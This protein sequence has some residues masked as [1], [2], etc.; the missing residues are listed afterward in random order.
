MLAQGLLQLLERDAFAFHLRGDHLAFA[1]DQ[2]G[3]AHHPVLEPGR[4]LGHE[5]ER[6]VGDEQHGRGDEAPDERVVVVHHAVLDGITE[7][8]QQ[9]Q[10]VWIHLAKLALAEQAQSADQECV[11]EEGLHG[12]DQGSLQIRVIEDQRQPVAHGA[13]L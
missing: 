10:V 6:L 1:Q 12:D 8:D 7:D 9:H 3:M 4:A 5:G 13:L 2:H 11:T